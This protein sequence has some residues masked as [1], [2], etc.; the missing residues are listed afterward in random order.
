MV[1]VCGAREIRLV[2]GEARSRHRFE[3]AI[4]TVL[5]AGV[6]VDGGVSPSQRETIIVI[7][8][9]LV[10][11][12]PSADSVALFAICA[13]LAPM[14]VGVTILAA[15]ADVGKNRL[16]VTLSAGHGSVHTTQRVPGLIVVKFRNSADRLPCA[17]G[18]AVLT[19]NREIAMRAPC[20]RGGLGSCA[21]GKC[22]KRKNQN[23]YKFRFYPSAH[24]LPLA[25]VLYPQ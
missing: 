9:V 10:R 11:D 4:G 8:D 15:L 1:R 16:N 17:C 19:R 3:S 7:L 12:L 18:M 5:V 20:A 23:D 13:Q 21:C 24:D 14:N 22:R 25:F 6:A 2:A